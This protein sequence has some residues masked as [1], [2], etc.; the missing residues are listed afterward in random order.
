M[1]DIFISYASEDLERVLPLVNALEKTAWSVFWDRTI[2]AGKTW[3][4]VIGAEIQGCRTVIVVWTE[5]SVNSEW[6]QEEAEIGRRRK[7]LVPVL[8]DKV[9][10]PFGFG[11][12]QAAN[13][14]AWRGENASPAF[15]RLVADIAAVLGPA[16]AAMKE[17]EGTDAELLGSLRSDA[18]ERRTAEEDRLREQERERIVARGANQRR[19]DLRSEQTWFQRRLALVRRL[20]GPTMASAAVAVLITFIVILR[21]PT[22]QPNKETAVQAPLTSVE[23]DKLISAAPEKQMEAPK[24]MPQGPVAELKQ[25]KQI[26]TQF[27]SV[28]KTFRDRL[29]SGTEGPEMVV[30]PAGSFQMGNVEG[31]GEKDETPVHAVTIQKPFAIGR[32]EGTFDEYDQFA[33]A[34]NR[35]PPADQGWGGGHRPVIN[36]SWEDVN[37]YVKW[38]SEQTGKRYRLPTE[39]E[40]EYAARAGR[41]TAYWWGNDFI[42]GMANCNGCGSQWDN[43]QTAPVGSFKPNALGLY[44]TAGNVW[45]WVEDCYHENFAGA[46]S[47]GRAWLKEKEG[48]CDLRVLRGG[49]W[50]NT[51]WSLRSPYRFRYDLVRRNG[52]IGFRLAQDLP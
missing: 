30:V 23:S 45:E 52:F 10:P 8:L 46:P 16:P 29:K 25:E 33:K 24:E 31:G 37:A 6:V 26:A 20:Y 1:S 44:D 7:I 21:W 49:S 9:E 39:A 32:Y 22:L 50:N 18:E 17:Q 36:V 41:E 38:L 47:D 2:P 42:K 28:G 12:I 13:L 3:R 48:Q 11:S 51:S 19:V 5:N 40:W 15:N 4:Q 27:S 35:K 34:T 43:K 14:V